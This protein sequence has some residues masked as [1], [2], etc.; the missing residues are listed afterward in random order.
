MQ[1]KI[2]SLFLIPCALALCLTSFS[3][4]SCS[5]DGNG[6]GGGG[7]SSSSSFVDTKPPITNPNSKLLIFISEDDPTNGRVEAYFSG[8]SYELR[9]R[10]E[11]EYKAADASDTTKI[12]KIVVNLI[13]SSG[14]TERKITP[15]D[16]RYDLNKP[17]LRYDFTD[18]TINNGGN[19]TI[20]VEVYLSDQPSKLA[21]IGETVQP[22]SKPHLNCRKDFTVDARVSP[23]NTGTVSVSPQGPYSNNQN[24][25]LSAVPTSGYAFFNWAD[26]QGYIIPDVGKDYLIRIGNENIYTANFVQ[27]R[28]FV[29]ETPVKVSGS[30]YVVL[31]G[32]NALQLVCVGTTCN[33]VAQESSEIIEKFKLRDGSENTITHMSRPGGITSPS[34][35]D[36]FIMG[37]GSSQQI[38]L[39]SEDYFVV[40]FS[41]N[42]WF[43]L[44]SKRGNGSVEDCTQTC[45]YVYVWK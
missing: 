21:G 10:G 41:S 7:G 28:N 12:S 42:N 17:A 1:K 5:D 26:G 15:N 39:N 2:Y 30:G 22:F 14:I 24:V 36:Q 16:E 18:C 25:T 4:I 13:G 44:A 40:K 38:E 6:G 8:N 19:Y 23:P 27:S 35:T 33:F 43:L 20:R 45:G 9:I 32:K 31:G 11:V 37:S 34:T 3:L 29:P